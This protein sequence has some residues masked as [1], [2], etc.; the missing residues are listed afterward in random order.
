MLTM[1][2]F[3]PPCAL[4]ACAALLACGPMEAP[5][6]PAAAP[7]ADAALV[8]DPW[9]LDLEPLERGALLTVPAFHGRT[10]PFRQETTQLEIEP[11]EGMEY[12]YRLEQGDTMLY[13]WTADFPLHVEMHSQPDGAPLFYANSFRLEDA[14]T[15]A[16]GSFTAP[17]PGIHGWYWENFGNDII[18]VTLTTSGFYRESQEFRSTEPAPIIR[19]IE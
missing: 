18:T 17:Y 7:P 9:R 1:L 19:A 5:A 8:D 6:P 4:V 3:R 16:H 10:E 14:I 11:G 2:P 13:S 15:E 12:K